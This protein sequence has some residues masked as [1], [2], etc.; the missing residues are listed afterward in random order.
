MPEGWTD[1]LNVWIS[2]NGK[3][4]IENSV[5]NNGIIHYSDENFLNQRVI[6]V[7]RTRLTERQ[8]RG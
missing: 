1:L 4:Q 2:D 8:E 5:M 3:I 6:D 7:F